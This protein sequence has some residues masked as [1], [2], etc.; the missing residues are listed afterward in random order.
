MVHHKQEEF[1]AVFVF[2]QLVHRAYG[3]AFLVKFVRLDVSDRLRPDSSHQSS[4]FVKDRRGIFDIVL[5]I[6]A[7]AEDTHHVR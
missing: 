3:T 4:G 7:A 2:S 6:M 5:V 1:H